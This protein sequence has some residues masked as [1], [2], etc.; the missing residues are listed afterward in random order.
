MFVILLSA[1]EARLGAALVSS[2]IP[3]FVGTFLLSLVLVYPVRL[4]AGLLRGRMN[5][6]KGK[7]GLGGR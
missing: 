5:T 7:G 1:G 6:K 2:V 3:E 4:L